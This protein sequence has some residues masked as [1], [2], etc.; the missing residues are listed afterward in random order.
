MLPVT[1]FFD[2]SADMQAPAPDASDRGMP[3]P[4]RLGGLAAA[5]RRSFTHS[6]AL[7]AMQAA[8]LW[9]MWQWYARRVGDGS[10]EPWGLLALAAVLVL[11]WARRH[12]L[13]AT[14]HAA[15]LLGA[16]MLTVLGAVGI[17]WLPPL[18]RAVL[19]V[20]ALALT[21]AAILD[22]SRPLLPLWALLVL[23]LP[24]VSSLQF[25]LGYP[26]RVLTAWASGRLLGLAGL[27]VEPAGA[28]L[29]WMGRTVLVD[30]PCSGI[31]M[32]WVGTFLAA[33]LSYLMRASP[34]RFILNAAISFLMV[35]AGNILRNSL[36]FVKEAGILRLPDWT[37]A[38]IGLLAFLLTAILIAVVTR[39]RSSAAGERSRNVALCHAPVS[40][41]PTPSL[42]T[43]AGRGEGKEHGKN[44]K[45]CSI[46]YGSVLF[47]GL[48]LTAAILPWLLPAARS[49]AAHGGPS[50]EAAWPAT[51]E[52]RPLTRLPLS[53]VERRFAAQFPG[54]IGR[55][56]D[57]T[58]H[59]IV[60]LV[61]GPTRM[62]HPASDCFR[63]LGYRVETPR[64]VVDG[65]GLAWSCFAAERDGR[66]RRVCERI[67]DENGKAW[68][69]VSS[70]YWAALLGR[71]S[72]PWVALTVV[73][74]Q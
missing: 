1:Q 18:A 2:S 67:Y 50:Q 7:V 56:T 64:V 27:P 60:R 32:L 39:W 12:A 22:R 59:L 25:Y 26:L 34:A 31:Q 9:P 8:G 49:H 61:Q 29:T 55:F 11:V 69:D 73:S 4:T 63:G 58:R 20:S 48:V 66:I 17:P 62:L 70:W 57:G 30:A 21:L 15:V 68:T 40:L 53:A 44:G 71:T 13:R 74:A 3:R 23:S 47:A 14:P 51:F 54:Q 38:A 41:F 24:V 36:L 35:L 16:G 72:H 6:L 10:D 37:H 19:G 46:R 5:L 33:L 42:F 43:L 65:A 45:A 28:A 52:G